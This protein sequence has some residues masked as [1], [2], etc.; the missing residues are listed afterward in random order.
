MPGKPRFALSKL[1]FESPRIRESVS[2]SR[3]VIDCGDDDDGK[4]SGRAR[5]FSKGDNKKEESYGD[6]TIRLAVS[7]ATWM[8]SISKGENCYSAVCQ[9]NRN[10]AAFR[11]K[12]RR[13][14]ARGLPK[15]WQVSHL[16]PWVKP[17]GVGKSSD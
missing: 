5:R 11:P 8:V 13:G 16:N 3:L 12:P 2:K 15:G 17:A 6:K 10:R 7:T 1:R 14:R 4:R 9:H